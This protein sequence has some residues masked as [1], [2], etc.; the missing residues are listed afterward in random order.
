M[1]TKTYSA[2]IQGI[3]AFPVTI[4]TDSGR[5]SVFSI[6][7][8]PDTAVKESHQRMASAI[9]HSGMKFP[10]KGV[11]INLAPADVKKEGAAFDLPMA[12]GLLT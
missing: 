6:V 1:L 11:T 7:G 2:A 10:N 5:G 8:L 4:E 3:D 12:I 9:I